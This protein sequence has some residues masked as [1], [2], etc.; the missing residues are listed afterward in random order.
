MDIM[1]PWH[2]EKMTRRALDSTPRVEK[3]RTFADTWTGAATNR[4]SNS[5][6]LSSRANIQQSYDRRALPLVERGVKTS[7]Q[8]RKS[9]RGAA[10]VLSHVF[11]LAVTPEPHLQLPE[12][13]QMT[14]IGLDKW[15]LATSA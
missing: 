9:S 12:A 15:F 14:Q 8:L 1:T 6:T 10:I 5:P 2:D 11:L 3:V 7:F 13:P 4:L